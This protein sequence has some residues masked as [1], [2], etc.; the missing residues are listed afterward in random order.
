MFVVLR[1]KNVFE[2]I[3]FFLFFCFKLIFFCVFLDHFDVLISKLIF[4]LKNYF[5]VFPSKKHFKKQ[6]QT[7]LPNT[8]DRQ[9]FN[10]LILT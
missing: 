8:L 4:F 5:N 2:K 1:F 3:E 9:R 6:L 10:S 7:T